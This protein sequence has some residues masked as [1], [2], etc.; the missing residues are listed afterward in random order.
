MH[1][2]VRVSACMC[3]CTCMCVCV[4]ECVCAWVCVQE[5]KLPRG[6]LKEA[7]AALISPRWKVNGG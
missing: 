4:H 3:V 6:S 7:G 1:A 5:M 2:Y